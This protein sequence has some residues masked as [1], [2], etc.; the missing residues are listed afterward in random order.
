MSMPSRFQGIT[1]CPW[2]KEP[3]APNGRH[4]LNSH[5]IDMGKLCAACS[6]L[7]GEIRADAQQH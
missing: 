5:G 7:A 1:K 4:F 6:S 3:S 2:C